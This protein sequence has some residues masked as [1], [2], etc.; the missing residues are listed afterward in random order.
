M[1]EKA[2]LAQNHMDLAYCLVPTALMAQDLV[3]ERCTVEEGSENLLLGLGVS[4]LCAEVSAESPR[5]NPLKRPKDVSRVC[6]WV[7]WVGQCVGTLEGLYLLYLLCC[8]GSWL[9]HTQVLHLL[10]LKCLSP[11]ETH[12]CNAARQPGAQRPWQPPLIPITDTQLTSSLLHWKQGWLK[13]T[14]LPSGAGEARGQHGDAVGRA[15]TAPAAAATALAPKTPAP[16]SSLQ[17]Q[18]GPE[19]GSSVSGGLPA[20]PPS[21]TLVCKARGVF[22]EE[23]TLLWIL[24]LTLI[25]T[26]L[27]FLPLSHSRI[28]QGIATSLRSRQAGRDRHPTIH[29]TD[30][31]KQINQAGCSHELT[32]LQTFTVQ[33]SFSCSEGLGWPSCPC[34]VMSYGWRDI[35]LTHSQ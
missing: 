33:T 11:A 1:V 13:T 32:Q 15:A 26:R 7:T 6:L 10:Q 20:L 17:E 12:S 2:S 9:Q 23:Q 4:L 14:R 16:T 35:Q 8:G 31:M 28:G 34:E 21:P 25:A 29:V 3:S 24:L 27:V 5:V 30:G 18:H 22:L 19:R